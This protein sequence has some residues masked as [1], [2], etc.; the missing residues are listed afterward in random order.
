MLFHSDKI[1]LLGRPLHYPQCRSRGNRPYLLSWSM[2]SI[3]SN[4]LF[5][6]RRNKQTLFGINDSVRKRGIS[7][8]LARNYRCFDWLREPNNLHF[9][10]NLLSVSKCHP[11]WKWKCVG[12]SPM[13]YSSCLISLTLCKLIRNNSFALE[14]MEAAVCLT[15]PCFHRISSRP[16]HPDCGPSKSE[17][18]TVSFSCL[19]TAK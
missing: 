10:W 14:Q 8:R 16:F 18:M 13:H 9:Q 11:K 17:V 19:S 7:V 12:L 4:I 3:I 6:L 1:T 15:S 2:H 5:T